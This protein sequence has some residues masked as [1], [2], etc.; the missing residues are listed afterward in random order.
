MTSPSVDNKRD[1]SFSDNPA[2]DDSGREHGPTQS[3][4]Y[5]PCHSRLSGIGKGTI[6][7]EPNAV[8]SEEAYSDVAPIAQVKNV[9]TVH[10]WRS[11]A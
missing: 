11:D 6:A 10:K 9:Q 3:L 1:I 8:F 5:R 7:L 4:L 2:E